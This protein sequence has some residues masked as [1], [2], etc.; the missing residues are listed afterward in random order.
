MERDGD[1]DRTEPPSRPRPSSDSEAP[2]AAGPADSRGCH[3]AAINNALHSD[4]PPRAASA[5]TWH[6]NSRVTTHWKKPS[7]KPAQRLYL[8][9]SH[10]QISHFSDLTLPF[11]VW[12]QRRPHPA[13]PRLQGGPGF[14]TLHGPQKTKP[15]KSWE[16]G[17]GRGTPRP[18]AASLPLDSVTGFTGSTGGRVGLPGF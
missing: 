6:E 8:I 13:A 5:S 15:R 2:A 3:S 18:P 9:W 16:W 10:I 4:S 7:M 1:A 14:L 17:G 12:L 11:C